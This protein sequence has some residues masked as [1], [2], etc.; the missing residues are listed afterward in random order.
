MQELTAL[1]GRMVFDVFPTGVAVVH[2]MQHGGPFP[3]TT[4]ARFTSVGA[5][6][7]D[8][9]LRPVAFQDA[10]DALLRFRAAVTETAGF[11]NTAGFV[12]DTR[13]FCSIPVRHEIARRCDAAYLAKLVAEHRLGLEEAAETI[14][15]LA[16]RLPK[17]IFKLE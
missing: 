6:A 13:A 7:I 17:R 11:Y 1:A 4:D 12:D 3:A 14:V 8:R 10:P 9:W 16:Y 15:D 5:R 2:A